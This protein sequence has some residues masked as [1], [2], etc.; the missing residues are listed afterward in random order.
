MTFIDISN[1]LA[2]KHKK[3][4]FRR[5]W[6]HLPAKVSN[7]NIELPQL[8]GGR[9]FDFNSYLQPFARNSQVS[10][11]HSS[12][13]SC[14]PAPHALHEIAYAVGERKTVERTILSPDSES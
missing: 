3:N 1:R 13:S 2:V 14:P 10:S 12:S 8:V 5:L 9:Y 7:Q 4:E 11:A 6:R